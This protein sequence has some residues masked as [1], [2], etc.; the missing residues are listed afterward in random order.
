MAEQGGGPLSSLTLR[1]FL[2]ANR[3]MGAALRAIEAEVVEAAARDEGSGAAPTPRLLRRLRGAHA[4]AARLSQVS[5]Q[6]PGPRTLDSLA[7]IVDRAARRVDN[8]NEVVLRIRS[9][10]TAGPGLVD[11][12]GVELALA[13]LLQNAVDAQDAAKVRVPVELEID[14]EAP[15]PP[16]AQHLAEAVRVRVLDSGA[17]LTDAERSAC[18]EPFFTT[19]ADREGLGLSV[20]GA[21]VRVGD[22][23]VDLAPRSEGR[24]TCATL[25]LRWPR[26]GVTDL[27]QWT[28]SQPTS[29][30][31]EVLVVAADA[32]RRELLTLM[33]EE[34]GVVVAAAAD[35]RTDRSGA[36]PAPR[37]WGLVVFPDASEPHEAAAL[38]A[39]L[40]GLYAFVVAPPV[41]A[42]QLAA[43]GLPEG[44]LQRTVGDRAEGVVEVVLEGL[45]ATRG[46]APSSEQSPPQSLQG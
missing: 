2:K 35:W 23:Q 16:A 17:G 44:R 40:S 21:L 22:A 12:D 38:V 28:E 46:S 43:S 3:R 24:G 39:W 18:F 29:G 42:D 7:A 11:A 45:T 6:E 37:P 15:L 27:P 4:L 32:R 14:S 26:P 25:W 5:R 10:G 41:L 1:A 36:Q 20:V 8:P 19:R 31:A 9:R 33:L 30:G 13:A 34:R